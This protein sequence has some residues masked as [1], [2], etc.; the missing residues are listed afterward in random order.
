MR[1]STVQRLPL[2]HEFPAKANGREPKTCLGQVFNYKL[3]CFDDLHVLIYVGAHPYLK[4][5]TWLRFS[6]VS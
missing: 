1:R 6:P 3:G 5:K 2:Q 4:L